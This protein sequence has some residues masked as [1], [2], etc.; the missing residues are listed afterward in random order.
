MDSNV[1]LQQDLAR[2]RHADLLR[3]A[4]EHRLAREANPKL[5]KPR[6][7]RTIARLLARFAPAQ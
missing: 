2:M 6:R 7:S 3:E 4:T 5:E 1:F